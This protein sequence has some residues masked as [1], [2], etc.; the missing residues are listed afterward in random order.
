MIQKFV[1]ELEDAHAAA[2]TVG[3]DFSCL[4]GKMSADSP[5]WDFEAD[6]RAALRKSVRVV[7]L[8]TGGGE[9]LSCLVDDLQGDVP[10]GQMI[11]ATEGWKENLWLAMRNLGKYRIPVFEYD[12]EADQPMPFAD[13]SL[14]LVMSRHEVIDAMEI[15]RVLVPGGQFLTQQ[16]DGLDAAELHDWFGSDFQYLG[17]NVG[18]YSKALESVGMEVEVA[19]EWEGAMTFADAKAL[20]TYM[21]LVPWD[22]PEFSV[23]AHAERLAELEAAKPIRVS[24]R[25]FLIHATKKRRS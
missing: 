8:G 15:S 4:E 10:L 25:R 21:G 16:V 1:E 24:Q 14:D 5:W 3:W 7:D 17:V 19:Q 2:T 13:Q 22:V 20:V 23:A 11:W 9:R 12:A 18:E 6:C